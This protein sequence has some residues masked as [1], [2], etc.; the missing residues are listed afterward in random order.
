MHVREKGSITRCRSVLPVRGCC[1][2]DIIAARFDG[3]AIQEV[4]PAAKNT[5]ESLFEV[6]IAVRLR[7]GPK[8]DQEISIAAGRV[9]IDAS[10]RRPENI[11][12]HDIKP[13]ASG[14]QVGPA[15]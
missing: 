15:S 8:R 11:Q 9:E 1:A 3:A 13:L 4:D 12:A 10:R 2:G 14:D 7:A 6:G 5:F